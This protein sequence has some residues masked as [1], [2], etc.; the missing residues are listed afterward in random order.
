MSGPPVVGCDVWLQQRSL[1][2]PGARITQSLADEVSLQP[3][4]SHQENAFTHQVP[5]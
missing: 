4:S 3:Y 1:E 2:D 5:A